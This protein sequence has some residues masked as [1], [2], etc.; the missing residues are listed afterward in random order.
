MVTLGLLLCSNY[1]MSDY[2]GRVV[3]ITQPPLLE[4]NEKTHVNTQVKLLGVWLGGECQ[5]QRKWLDNLM[6]LCSL[7]DVSRGKWTLLQMRQSRIQKN[8]VISIWCVIRT[9]TNV[10]RILRKYVNRLDSIY[11]ISQNKW[12]FCLFATY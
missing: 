6:G 10:G 11:S 4:A 5:S 8:E 9:E 1:T 12:D 2:L 3:I 7:I